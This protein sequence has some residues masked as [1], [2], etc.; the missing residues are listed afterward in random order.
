M[1]STVRTLGSAF[2]HVLCVIALWP[3]YI[4]GVI[5]IEMESNYFNNG[6]CVN[7]PLYIWELFSCISK[8]RL[9]H[10]YYGTLGHPV[11]RYALFTKLV[12]ILWSTA[13]LTQEYRNRCSAALYVSSSSSTYSSPHRYWAVRRQIHFDVFQSGENENSMNDV[14]TINTHFNV[15]RLLM[16]SLCKQALVMFKNATLHTPLLCIKSILLHVLKVS[17][18]YWSPSK[19]HFNLKKCSLGTLCFQLFC[20]AIISCLFYLYVNPYEKAEH[21]CEFK[22]ICNNFPSIHAQRAV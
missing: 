13:A 5:G 6:T 14:H 18:K 7:R 11:L 3:V 17:K 16:C 10:A 21:C 22:F 9:F 20:M 8:M 2:T 4:I 12:S 1:G 19:Y 15:L